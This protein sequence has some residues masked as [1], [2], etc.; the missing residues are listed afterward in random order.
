[1]II[2][3]AGTYRNVRDIVWPGSPGW[4]AIQE[5]MAKRFHQEKPSSIVV[6]VGP[7]YEMAT[8][9][10]AISKNIPINVFMPC[11]NN[12]GGKSARSKSIIN[13]IIENA[14]TFEYRVEGNN[15]GV[16]KEKYTDIAKR[17]DKMLVCYGPNSP[18]PA[19]NCFY[20][21]EQEGKQYENVYEPIMAIQQIRERRDDGS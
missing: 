17:S 11:L 1:M 10:L 7:G 19:Q 14:N 2:G 4:D 8:A 20:Y 21:C 12:F 13:Y 5:Y 3:V 18:H 6:G 15:S 16:M 9:T